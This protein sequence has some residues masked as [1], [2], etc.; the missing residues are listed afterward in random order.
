MNQLS[1]DLKEILAEIRHCA[2]DITQQEWQELGDAIDKFLPNPLNPFFLLPMVTGIGCHGKREELTRTAAVVTLLDVCFRIMDDCADRDD[3]TSLD[4][5][6]GMGRAIHY[7]M[8]INAIA[9]QELL[10]FAIAPPSSSDLIPYYFQSFLQVCQGQDRDLKTN[11]NSLQEYQDLIKLKTL[12][13]YQFATVIGACVAA[14]DPQQ[15]NAAA[16]F[17][18]H[19]GWMT[20]MLD[21][22]ESIWFPT[23]ENQRE[24]EK[25]TFPVLLGLSLDHPNAERLEKMFHQKQYHR[26]TICTLLDEMDIRTR[27]IHS[28][29]NHRDEALKSLENLPN[30]EGKAI[31]QIWLDWYLGQGER[32]LQPIEPD[33]VSP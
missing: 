6:V 18:Q 25:K 17:G 2:I 23:V 4:R 24:I 3:P 15:L 10:N 12:P 27:L 31:L 8:A 9:T 26:K 28:A 11:V 7:A 29:L 14:A 5:Q 22:I 33:S 16:E 20:Q 19:L 1:V 21:D 13:A 32:L 30:S